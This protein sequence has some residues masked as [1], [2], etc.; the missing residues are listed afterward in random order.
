MET[1]ATEV[2]SFLNSRPSVLR[3]CQHGAVRL[4]HVTGCAS[5]AT[6]GLVRA[7]SWS[8]QGSKLLRGSL[9]TMKRFSAV[10]GLPCETLAEIYADFFGHFVGYRG[11]QLGQRIHDRENATFLVRKM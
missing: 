10:N 7:A 6:G 4:R 11:A 5:P 8:R 3:P 1:R 2:E 9:S